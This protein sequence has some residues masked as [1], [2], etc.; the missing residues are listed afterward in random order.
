MNN[1]SE[2]QL[3]EY[4]KRRGKPSPELE[5]K[6]K[7]KYNN[8]IVYV[9]GLMFRSQKEAD[10]YGELKLL[11]RSGDIL[12]F[13]CQPEFVLVDGSQEQRPITYKADYLVIY[14]GM[15]CEV[16]DVKGYETEAFKRTYKMFKD[17]YP[18][19]ELKILK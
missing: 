8:S 11:K 18:D 14:P 3:Q 4:L 1:W 7:P 16:E 5:K 2:D 15:I 12:G 19:I 13:I 17:R 6:K 10:R 9:D